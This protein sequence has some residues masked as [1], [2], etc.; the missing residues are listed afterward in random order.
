MIIYYINNKNFILTGKFHNSPI[1]LT[2]YDLTGK[3]LR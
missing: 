2:F 3:R 1:S